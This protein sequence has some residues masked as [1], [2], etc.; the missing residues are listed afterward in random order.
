MSEQAAPGDE[1]PVTEAQVAAYL[2]AD[3]HF[4]ERHL[5]LLVDLVLPHPGTG[6]AVSLIERQVS[7]LRDQNRE[8][9][10][11]LHNLAQTARTNEQLLDRIQRLILDLVGAPTLRNALET[12]RAALR[13]DFHADAITVRLFGTSEREPFIRGDD[14]GL[15]PLR[16]ILDHGA[17]VCG[18]LKPEQLTALFGDQGAEIASGALIPLC[19]SREEQC[20]GFLAIGS[21]DPK[22]FHAEMGTVFL[23]QLGAVFARLAQTRWG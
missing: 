2:A 13:E 12:L 17:P 1:T 19:E 11:K 6:S 8:L 20:L 5:R 15:A 4:F 10:H 16:K 7:V 3:P 21:I 22:R 9:R 23:R 14:A 18:H